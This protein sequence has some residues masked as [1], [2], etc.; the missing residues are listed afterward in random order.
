M[1]RMMD[2]EIDDYFERRGWKNVDEIESI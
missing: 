2:R 1:R